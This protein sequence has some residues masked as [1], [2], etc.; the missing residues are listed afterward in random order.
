MNA[1]SVRVYMNQTD[2][3][4]QLEFFQIY[5]NG[6]FILHFAQNYIFKT[7]LI[8]LGAQKHVL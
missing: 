3:I 7:F 8:M 2:Y 5:L 1:G 4:I 6:F